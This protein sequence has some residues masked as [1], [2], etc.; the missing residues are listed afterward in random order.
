MD[1]RVELGKAIREARMQRRLSIQ[2][3][4][5]ATQMAFKSIADIEQ[6]RTYVKLDSLLKLC[7]A[8]QVKPSTLFAVVD[9]N[10]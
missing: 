3:L 8:L 9:K 10:L 1:Y 5:Y 4:H 2:E 6:G 7:Q